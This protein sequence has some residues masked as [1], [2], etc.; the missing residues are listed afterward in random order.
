MTDYTPPEPGFFTRFLWFCSGADEQILRKCPKYDHVKYQGLGGVVLATG[1]LAFL[2][3]S[4]AF[5]TIFSPK[6]DTALN[7]SLNV[8]TPTVVQAV[9]FGVLWDPF[10]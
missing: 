9:V 10:S 4:Y 1:M 7:A 5:Y 2:S 6:T 8:H 3:G